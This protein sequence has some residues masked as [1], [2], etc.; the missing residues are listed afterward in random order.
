MPLDELDQN[1]VYQLESDIDN[2]YI[3]NVIS[4]DEFGDYI[5][6]LYTTGGE[7]WK[8]DTT[9]PNPVNINSLN[10][11]NSYVGWYHI[12]NASSD[13]EL[14]IPTRTALEQ[15]NGAPLLTPKQWF[16]NNGHLIV[17][18][19]LM[20]QTEDSPLS[21]CT[22]PNAVNFNP[23]ASID[24]GTCVTVNNWLLGEIPPDTMKNLFT[25]G[26]ELYNMETGTDYQG[27]YHIQGPSAIPTGVS[28]GDIMMGRKYWLDINDKPEGQP[29]N[30][31]L[32][33]YNIDRLLYQQGKPTQYEKWLDMIKWS[34]V[35][36]SRIKDEDVK[37]LEDQNVRSINGTVD[38][39]YKIR[40]NNTKNN[41]REIL[42]IDN[43][44]TLPDARSVME[45]VDF[46]FNQLIPD[47]RLSPGIFGTKP[48][49]KSDVNVVKL[50]S[51]LDGAS[52]ENQTTKT[53]IGISTAN[54]GAPAVDNS[55][56]SAGA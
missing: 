10:D 12:R 50:G 41:K 9:V 20:E 52:V 32:I 53:I 44:I 29:D 31:L 26:G 34:Q 46:E 55:N 11:A 42:I 4:T 30:I 47:P 1:I 14:K 45:D 16:K 18:E 19:A 7:F 15:Y 37:S 23:Y 48:Q 13:V 36:R 24:N 40:F 28:A 21:G 2:T 56:S 17:W 3:Y 6:D 33:P 8:H 25:E 49:I 35:L 27:Y 22:N 43:I 51:P 38:R 54:A 5:T 39:P